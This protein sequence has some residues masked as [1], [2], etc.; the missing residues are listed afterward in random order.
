MLGG[1]LHFNCEY[2]INAAITPTVSSYTYTPETT[3]TMT[4]ATPVPV[5]SPP[6][7]VTDELADAIF[8]S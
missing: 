1:C 6:V 5:V 8:T 7:P 4:V 3:L 2:N